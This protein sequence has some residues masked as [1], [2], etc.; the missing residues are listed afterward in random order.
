MG[1]PYGAIEPVGPGIRRT[2]AGPPVPPP[3]FSPE[4]RSANHEAVLLTTTVDVPHAGL[5]Q[6]EEFDA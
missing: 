6:A 1:R 5:G 4:A 3:D 2:G